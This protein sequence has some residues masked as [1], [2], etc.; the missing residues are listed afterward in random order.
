M[1]S[2][3][4]EADTPST[5]VVIATRDRPRSLERCLGIQAESGA[6]GTACTCDRY[7]EFMAAGDLPKRKD[8]SLIDVLHATGG[9]RSTADRDVTPRRARR[10]T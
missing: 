10:A 1:T 5:S 8:T 6:A 2:S 7:R 9:P 4:T 3:N